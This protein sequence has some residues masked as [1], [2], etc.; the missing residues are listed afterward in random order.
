MIQSKSLFGR[1][2]TF[3][4]IRRT[5]LANNYCTSAM[6]YYHGALGIRE[7]PFVLTQQNQKKTHPTTGNTSSLS[8]LPFFCAAS[9]DSLER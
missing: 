6:K 5:A 2:K 3:L 8:S 7:R 9:H 4:R 1:R